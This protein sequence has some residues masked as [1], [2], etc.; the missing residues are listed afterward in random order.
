V[1]WLFGQVAS[2]AVAAAS[3]PHPTTFAGAVTTCTCPG[4]HT[5]EAC[6]MHQSG[7]SARDER[8]D[9]SMRSAHV[10]TDTAL[11]SLAAGLG[12]PASTSIAIGP[13]STRPI[14]LIAVASASATD[15]PDSPPPRA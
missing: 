10:P 4:D 15:F 11:L 9:C 5:D 3:L 14:G 2:I 8:D 1:V 6:P 7:S 13:A 12:I